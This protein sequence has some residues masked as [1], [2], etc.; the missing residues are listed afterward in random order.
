MRARS[1][2]LHMEP[3]RALTARV[4]GTVLERAGVRSNA[5]LPCI[6][7]DK[8]TPGWGVLLPV[9]AQCPPNC[10]SIP[11]ACGSPCSSQVVPTGPMAVE[12]S[13]PC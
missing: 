4:D 12:G 8:R 9:P 13:P 2:E 11:R 6:L 1:P 3:G 10:E 7:Q 5:Q